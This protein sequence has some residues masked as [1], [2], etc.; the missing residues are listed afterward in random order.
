MPQGSVVGPLLFAMFVCDVPALLSNYISMFADDTKIYQAITD[1]QEAQQ[2][3]LQ[4][5]LNTIQAWARTMQM[6]FHPA[7]CKVMH[8]GTRNANMQYTMQERDGQTHTLEEVTEE[9]DLGVTVD[10]ELSFAKHV[11]NQVNKANRV[12]GAVR[13]T[14]KALDQEAFRHLYTGLVRPHLEY[15]SVA[16]APRWKRERDALEQVQRRATRLVAGISHLPYPERLE[17]LQLPTLEH[18]RKRAD[19]IQTY[20]ILHGIDKVEYDRACQQCGNSMF[21]RTN[22]RRTRG[23][24]WKLFNQHQPGKRKAFLPARVTALWNQLKEETVQAPTVNSFK[25]RLQKEEQLQAN[26]YAYT[27]SYG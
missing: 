13:H 3:N 14:F 20:K 16:W 8:L 7:K 17:R 25:A 9:K 18:R 2:S 26:Q 15:A 27:F 24:S 5:D 4:E 12:L 1:S 10:R 11:Q 6:T 23:H 21:K 22:N 19:L